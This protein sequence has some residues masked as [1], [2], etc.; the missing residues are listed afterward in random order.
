MGKRVAR[1]DGDAGNN[2]EIGTSDPDQIR[3]FGGID[4]L[5]GGNGNDT[6]EGGD[7]PDSLYGDRDDDSIQGGAG[8]DLIRGGR[9]DDTL[10]GG[11]GRDMIRAD[12][13][14][15][16]I[17]G[18]EGGDY[19]DGG[20]GYDVVDYTNSPRGGGLYDGVD[21][22][23]SS[24]SWL[25][26][27]DGGHAEGDI[28]VGV[29]F[30]AGSPYD[31]RIDVGDLW[32][33]SIFDDPVSHGA[34]GGAGD[35][36]LWGFAVDHL[37]GGPGDD[38]LL[39]HDGGRAEGGPGAD[40]FAFFGNR[41]NAAIDDFS[42][43]EG[44]VISL[45]AVGFSGATRA[46]VEAMLD[47]S[48]GNVLDLSLL[49]IAGSDHG[50]ITLE[51]IQ[52]SSLDVG[53]FVLEG[54]VDV[55]DVDPESG[56]QVAGYDEIAYQLT[57]GYWGRRSFNVAPSGTLTADITALTMKGQQLARWA[58]D[59]W[60][61]V[62]GIEFQFVTGVADITFDDDEPG[63]SAVATELWSNGEI[64][65]AH[66]NVS[67]D[68][69]KEHGTTIDS[70]SFQSYV[71]EI[72]HALGLGHPGDYNATDDY[73]PTYED[74]AKFLNDSWQ[75]TV[76]S[77]FDQ[78]DNTYIDASQAL[79]VTPMIAD[80]IAIQNLYGVPA[81]INPGDTVYGYGSNLGG[82]LGLLFGAMSGEVPDDDVYAGGPVAL[83]IHDS[84]GNDTLDLRWDLDD[85]R[86]DLRPEGIS[87]V[88][89][90][91]GNLLIARGTFIETYVA[92]SG[93]DAVTGNDAGNILRGNHGNDTL[94]G[95]A[96]DDW[97][98]GGPGADR[99]EGGAGDDGAFYQWSDAG[100]RV[101]LGA[102]TA[103]GGDAQGDSFNDVEHLEGS[104][105]RDTLTGDGDT[106]WLWGG[107]GDDQLAGLGGDDWL[108]GGMGDDVLLGG[109][110]NDTFTF[111]GEP[112]GEDVIRD[113]GDDRSS[114]GEQDMIQLFGD[115]SFSSLTLTA[116]G[117]DV[118]I[119]GSDAAGSIHVTLENYL[120][121]HEM[122][123]LGPDDFLFS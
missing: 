43:G 80:I 116:S 64:R 58:L 1:I 118:V 103:A 77:Y 3:G 11:A 69:L 71:H 55:V 20:D 75:A 76:M 46:D 89:G 70:Y 8:D 28:L 97:L 23:V 106:N 101:H 18:S 100:I 109:G 115:F 93:D 68:W 90:L 48:E 50:T 123:D 104:S 117:A 56:P 6:I 99:L 17:M 81:S 15:D 66:V 112:S 57:D 111:G 39:L 78:A 26:L 59:A 107:D 82:Y 108:A 121:D 65:K 54:A 62:T 13:G 87:D 53:D 10:D 38:T 91:T 85:Q 114:T 45:S 35:D 30:V 29:E 51:G 67:V 9:G 95:G 102:G 52:V 120:V 96:G 83:T 61:N 42:P 40:T 88:L 72:G 2:L 32:G 22:D 41:V 33:E 94:S 19:I 98:E 113:F 12:L 25:A 74:D 63:A 7:G 73:T 86:V 21:V 60:S 27:G 84:G 16:W 47:G 14:D 49:G 24:S 34:Y 110:G 119:T 79:A 92:G 122:S 44:D 36:E 31:D 4:L 5:R 37:L 105:Y